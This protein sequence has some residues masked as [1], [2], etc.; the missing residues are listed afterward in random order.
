MTYMPLNS[1]FMW[2]FWPTDRDNWINRGRKSTT[3]HFDLHSNTAHCRCTWG[4]WC[5]VKH[6]EDPYPGLFKMLMQSATLYSRWWV[7]WEPIWLF[8]PMR[9]DIVWY[10]PKNVLG[11]WSLIQWQNS[12]WC[13][14]AQSGRN[15]AL[16]LSNGVYYGQNLILSEHICTCLM[17]LNQ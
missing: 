12:I 1:T 6:D 17:S 11:S 9:E 4:K 15:F 16:S 7:V 5:V 10:Q 3:F 14:M 8:W 13:L 2:L